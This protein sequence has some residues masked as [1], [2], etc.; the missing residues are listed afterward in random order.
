MNYEQRSYKIFD[1]LQA[2]FKEKDR[3]MLCFVLGFFVL[4]CC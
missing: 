3:S 1:G 2:D 4:F